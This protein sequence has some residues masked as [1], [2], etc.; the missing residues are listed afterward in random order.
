[1][2][3]AGGAGRTIKRTDV[4]CGPMVD[5]SG[6]MRAIASRRIVCSP[7]VSGRVVARIE[8]ATVIV[9]VGVAAASL[10]GTGHI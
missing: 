9:R 8:R 7:S 5:A 10:Y 6:D 4:R 2:E 3:G 1:M